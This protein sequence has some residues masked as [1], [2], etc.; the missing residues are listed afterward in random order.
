M[1]LGNVRDAKQDVLKILGEEGPM[2]CKRLVRKLIEGRLKPV[3]PFP[4]LYYSGEDISTAFYELA[5]EQGEIEYYDE[6]GVL[7]YRLKAEN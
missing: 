3:R 6:N 1:S 5:E 4:D 7:C 2:P